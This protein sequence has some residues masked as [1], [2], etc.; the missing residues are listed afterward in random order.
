[1]SVTA[2]LTLHVHECRIN[3]A[4]KMVETIKEEL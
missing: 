2:P 4:R 1:M 3:A